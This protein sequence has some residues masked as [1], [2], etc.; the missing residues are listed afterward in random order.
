MI[1]HHNTLA[2][3]TNTFVNL[4]CNVDNERDGNRRRKT[5]SLAIKSLRKYFP[6]DVRT[7]VSVSVFKVQAAVE[8]QLQLKDVKSNLV[9][10]LIELLVYVSLHFEDREQK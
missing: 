2:H 7:Q 1:Y 9:F 4:Y 3:S 8:A 10:L 5:R 6:N